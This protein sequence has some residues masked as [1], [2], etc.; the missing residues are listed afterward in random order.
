MRLQ[1]ERFPVCWL[2][3]FSAGSF[4]SCSASCEPV[5]A[6][7]DFEAP[8][9]NGLSPGWA[10]WSDGR[11][12]PTW[13]VG[14]EPSN[15]ATSGRQSQA[16]ILNGNAQSESY[17]GVFYRLEC[18]RG[19]ELYRV[20]FQMKL[21]TDS[22]RNT[23]VFMGVH[24]RAGT[25]F[26][27]GETEWDMERQIGV[28]STEEGTQ[29]W[30]PVS[31]VFMAGAESSAHTLWV[32]GWR[33][34]PATTAAVI[35]ID[36]IAIERIP[37]YFTY[38]TGPALDV[39][40]PQT[41]GPNLLVNGGFE[42]GFAGPT[43][44]QIASGWTRWLAAGT[45][46]FRPSPDLGKF[47]SGTYGNAVFR[48]GQS[49]V[50]MNSKVHL[51]CVPNLAFD[52]K[53]VPGHE[54]CIIIGR[55]IAIDDVWDY[56]R[57]HGYP[58]PVGT[59]I[60][61][62]GDDFVIQMGRWHAEISAAKQQIY[63]HIDAWQ[64]LNEPWIQSRETTR[65]AALFEAAFAQRCT[66]LGI[67]S[68]ILA[69]AVGNPIRNEIIDI[70]RPA[71]ELADY[72][73]PHGYGA[74]PLNG[75]D[76]GLMI[77]G[78]SQ[79]EGNSLKQRSVE[80]YCRARGYRFPPVILG[81]VG[82]YFGWHD[83]PGYPTWPQYSPQ[84]IAQDYVAATREYD[85][86]PWMV[87]ACVFVTGGTGPWQTWDI[88][89]YPEIISAIGE[90]NRA[91]SQD[92][93]GG[94]AQQFGQRG[95]SFR[96]GICQRVNVVA[97]RRY[98]VRG[99]FKFAHKRGASPLAPPA[100]FYIGTDPTGQT[101]DGN[102]ATIR[103]SIDQI[104]PRRLNSDVWYRISHTVEATSNVLSVWFAAAQTV[105]SPND[106]HLIVSLD[107]LALYETD[108]PVDP[109][110]TPTSTPVGPTPTP[111]RTGAT[112]ATPTATSGG[113]CAALVQNSGFEAGN[114]GWTSNGG[115]GGAS[116]VR[117][118]DGTWS[119][120]WRTLHTGG[121]STAHVYQTLAV[122]PGMLYELSAWAWRF[123]EGG[124]N[125]DVGV[126]LV[127]DPTGGT[128]WSVE[129]AWV[130]AT[131]A[132]ERLS[133]LVTPLTGQMTVGAR[134]VQNYNL[135]LNEV[136]VDDFALVPVGNQTATPA[137]TRT[138]SP[139]A[140]V[141]G[142]D[143][144][145]DGI[146]DALEP[147]DPG[148]FQSH[149]Y[150]PDSDGD[151]LGDGVEDT[152]RNGLPDGGETLTRFQ[153]SDG[154]RLEDGVEVLLLGTGPLHPT[155]PGSFTDADRDGLPVTHD[156][157]DNSPDADAD[158]FADGYE[159]VHVGLAATFDAHVMPPLADVNGDSFITN[160]D[161]LAIQTVFIGALPYELIR[162][163]RADPNRDGY[164]T[165]IDALVA[166]SF[167]LS[168]LPQLPTGGTP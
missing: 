88:S 135:P 100:S 149:R 75:V 128:S 71:Y 25:T 145:G 3:L 162:A 96:G 44:D 29:N 121:N 129:S 61:N 118:H 110:Q 101:T 7:G 62:A 79:P 33:K 46:F 38:Q 26:D 159:A 168:I 40:L 73:V 90:H 22:E 43:N 167:F 50:T 166:Q 105:N 59:T 102:A 81:E 24:Y 18:L 9:V 151:G 152:N 1:D 19:G 139:S 133:V 21:P 76:S 64:G 35:L 67:K 54:D 34:W 52:I 115:Q 134:L 58:V 86:D 103:W 53:Q 78:N 108:G 77:I 122:C 131:G 47:G 112:T 89:P 60:N 93:R 87:G 23:R 68:A 74:N 147:L 27:P 83:A 138:P 85:K 70:L 11:H 82:T 37:P 136:F 57:E 2:L 144:D 153:D 6:H 95:T 125:W 146:P 104:K 126:R 148:P 161:A 72:I 157:N 156:L 158:R 92:A 111:T 164:I 32:F 119:W 143:S 41:S 109:A 15:D 20:S 65:K 94:K 8:F 107:N 10:A 5:I 39:N 160:V 28:G 49:Y 150:L 140:T 127:A 130:V 55:T 116:T 66:E 114:S 132:W 113:S 123:Q 31:R 142:P 16:I 56:F 141:F 120:G 13:R 163:G 165:N 69:L 51:R 63:P 84:Q 98:N 106:P 117:A 80:A 137:P 99:D 155:Q 124:L 154:D 45:G 30:T 12:N 4:A 97:G 17:G 91:N 14:V 36:D 48:N 42:G